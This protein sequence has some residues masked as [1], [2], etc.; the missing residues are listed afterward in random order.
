MVILS[1]LINCFYLFIF[2]CIGSSLL[3]E[4]SLVAKQN[5]SS[6]QFASYN[7]LQLLVH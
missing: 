2:D 5:Y 6:L 1:E 3:C 7:S 4:V